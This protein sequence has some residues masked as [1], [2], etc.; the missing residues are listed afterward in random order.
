MYGLP[1][2]N[3]KDE[4]L[5]SMLSQEYFGIRPTKTFKNRNIL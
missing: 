1:F 5:K 2:K 3:W 4:D